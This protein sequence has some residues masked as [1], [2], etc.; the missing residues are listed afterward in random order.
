MIRLYLWI[1]HYDL[2]RTYY[3]KDCYNKTEQAKAQYKLD[4]CFII[5]NVNEYQFLT[6]GDILLEKGLLG[7]AATIKRFEH[8][9]LGSV[10]KKQAKIAKQHYQK[11][12]KQSLWIW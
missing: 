7:K 1:I 8:S 5:K 2:G 11:L 10:L 6:G 9:L 12:G 3:K 4:F